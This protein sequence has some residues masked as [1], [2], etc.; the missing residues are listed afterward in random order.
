MRSP[1][2]RPGC[3][4]VPTTFLTRMPPFSA[5][6]SRPAPS[7]GETFKVCLKVRK[8]LLLLRDSSGTVASLA[9]GPH[10]LEDARA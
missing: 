3:P 6:K 9:L 10:L 1:T 7:C 4:G 8:L 5:S 2:Y